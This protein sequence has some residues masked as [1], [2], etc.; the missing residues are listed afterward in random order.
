[1]SKTKHNTNMKMK[2]GTIR[3]DGMVFWKKDSRYKNNEYWITKEKY[4][5]WTN[6]EKN[7]ALEYASN[8]REKAKIKSKEWREKNKEKH[9]AYSLNWQKQNA[10]KV[11]LKNKLWKKKNPERYKEFQKKYDASVPE[12]KRRHAAS[13]RCKKKKIG[14]AHV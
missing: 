3:E 7:K 1:M 8:N 10:E 12:T 2:R 14:R 4:D 13:R 6:R 11:N 5:Q 9:R